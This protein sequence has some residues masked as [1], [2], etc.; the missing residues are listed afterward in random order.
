LVLFDNIRNE[1][2]GNHSFS[3][4]VETSIERENNY[5]RVIDHS[6]FICRS[7]QKVYFYP[8]EVRYINIKIVGISSDVDLELDANNYHL[9]LRSFQCKLIDEAFNI[10]RGILAPDRRMTHY[11]EGCLLA[12]GE[13]KPE[14]VIPWML[15]PDCDENYFRR[16]FSKRFPRFL[17]SLLC[18]FFNIR[19]HIRSPQTDHISS[20]ILRHKR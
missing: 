13:N 19:A 2:T 18:G 1:R 5:F 3:Y 15:S 7:K 8:R 17:R 16:C 9:F 6:E 14:G 20:N 10:S 11:I 4:Y 12:C